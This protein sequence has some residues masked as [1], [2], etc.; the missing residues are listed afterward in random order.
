MG[1]S[2][3]ADKKRLG[4][5][6]APAADLAKVQ[7]RVVGVIRRGQSFLVTTH[8][9]PD[10]DGIGSAAGLAEALRIL[11]KD[12]VLYSADPIPRTYDFMPETAR[13]VRELPRDA[14]FDATLVTDCAEISRLGP[15]VPPPERRGTLVF[16]DHHLTRGD[17][18]DLDFNDDT[19]PAVGEMVLRL[20]KSLGVPLTLSMAESLYASLL[21]DT[22]SF[23]YANTSPVAMRCAAELLE[24][25]VDPWKVAS[26][27]FESQPLERV[28]LLARVLSTIDV[29]ADG[30]CATL[31]ASQKMLGETGATAAMVDGLVNYARSVSGVEVA[32]LFFE[33][34]DG[35]H[36]VSFRSRGSVNVAAIAEIFGG[37]GHFHAAGCTVS[38]DYDAVR[39]GIYAAVREAL[40]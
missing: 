3:L 25:G 5:G 36:K 37:G 21:S 7:A 30:R 17:R 31:V 16:L 33:L 27:L 32:V 8:R 11:G 12:V 22:G 13:F 35:T 6:S 2:T 9:S 14:R 1:G 23:R 24:G 34:A 29:S 10:T 26:S 4:L 20:V 39:Q 19:S 28:R 38:G 40:G 18:P 15:H